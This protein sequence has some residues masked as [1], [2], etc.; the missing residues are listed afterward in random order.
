M[1]STA[2]DA[3]GVHKSFGPVHAVNDVSLRVERGEIVALLGPNGAGKTTF[4]DMVLGFTT[5]DDGALQVLGSSPQRAVRAGLVG[6]VL[7]TGGLLD[8]LTVHETLTMVSACLDH[9]IPIDDAAHRAGITH[10]LKRKVRKISGGEQQRLRFALA[11]LSDPVLLILDEPTAGMDVSARTKFWAT[12]HTE[13]ERG[14]TVVF[15]THYLQEASDFADR[16]ILLRGGKVAFDGGVGEIGAGRDATLTCRWMSDADPAKV[17]ARVGAMLTQPNSQEAAHSQTSRLRF[18]SG[19]T[20]ALARVLLNENHAEKLE[21]QAATLDEIFR[22]LTADP[23][24]AAEP[25][26]DTANTRMFAA[27][28]KGA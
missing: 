9:H 28:R 1:N 20:D 2:I 16:I 13:A 3:R 26:H 18:T 15:A 10:I 14:R 25:T 22:D 12:M 5:P 7:Q 23:A 8:D 17:A 21:I 19:D 11:L 27:A 24:P 6:A 4:L